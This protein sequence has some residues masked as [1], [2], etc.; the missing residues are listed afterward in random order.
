M[1]EFIEKNRSLL[2]SYCIIT[3]IVGW[4]LLIIAIV[5]VIV[6]PLSG[7]SVSEEHRFFMIYMLCQQI[8]LGYV[9]LAIVLLGLAQFVRYISES[10]YQP[11]MILSH[12]GKVLYLYAVALI[13]S[14]FL[15]YYFQMKAIGYPGTNSIFLYSLSALLPAVAK[16]LIYIGMAKVL[17][18]MMPMVEESKTLV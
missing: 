11:G 15:T 4:L 10:K 16:A 18:R 5:L 1:N 2:R 7:F 8:V 3:R 17:K 6:K 13:A 14:P 9:L 12:G